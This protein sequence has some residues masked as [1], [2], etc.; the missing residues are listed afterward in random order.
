LTATSSGGVLFSCNNCPRSYCIECLDLNAIESIDG[1]LPEYEG[2]GYESPRH[3]QYITCEDCVKKSNG[4]HSK[5][6]MTPIDGQ[7]LRNSKRVRRFAF[8]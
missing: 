1:E 5:R 6:D 3:F 7:N 8:E 4:K 2:L